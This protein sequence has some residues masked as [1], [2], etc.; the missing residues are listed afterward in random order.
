MNHQRIIVLILSLFLLL[1]AAACTP[2]ENGEAQVEPTEA[3]EMTATAT[4]APSPSPTAGAT[5]TDTPAPSP[6]AT[7]Q[8]TATATTAPTATATTAPTATATTA[9]TG[10]QALSPET[11]CGNEEARSLLDSLQAAADEE[12]EEQLAQLIHP[13]RGLR[14]RV[15]WWNPE[16]H[17]TGAEVETLLSSEASYEWGSETGSGQA[18]TGSF[19]EVVLPRLEQ[20]LVA[21]EEAGCNEILHG[22][23]AGMVQLPEE[24]AYQDV[25]YF[26]LYRPAPPDGIEF[27]WGT[28][29]IGVEEWEGEL[30]ITF[31]VHY[32]W[33]I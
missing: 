1:A 29:A 18:I 22:P 7:A 24:E 11:F 2:S 30:R 28:W 26:S 15:N 31:L 32:Q 14:V 12:D 33:E 19:S 6:S 3:P 17:L 5:A 23:T 13:E 25:T 16:I 20:D 10:S 9:E 27:D 21:A 8:P 4:T